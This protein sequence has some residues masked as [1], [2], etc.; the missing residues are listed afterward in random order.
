MSV[1]PQL[2]EGGRHRVL[3]FGPYPPNGAEEQFSEV[4]RIKRSPT[5][6]SLRYRTGAK[7]GSVS[8]GRDASYARDD[9]S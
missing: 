5:P 6:I 7:R 8:H 3:K 1:A 4:R 2:I 9:Y